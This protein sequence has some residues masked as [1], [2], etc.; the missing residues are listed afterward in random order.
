M[1]DKDISSTRMIWDECL[2]RIEKE[3]IRSQIFHGIGFPY[4]DFT[5][6]LSVQFND[7]RL[8]TQ[9]LIIQ[10]LEEEGEQFFIAHS[11]SK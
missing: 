10:F 1:K 2:S 5:R 8:T 3:K 11:E 4:I 9:R 7:L 6:I